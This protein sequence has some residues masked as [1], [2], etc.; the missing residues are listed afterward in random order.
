MK[1]I[2]ILFLIVMLGQGLNAQN[3]KSNVFIIGYNPVAAAAAKQSAESGVY[4]EWLLNIGGVGPN[5][6]ISGL[7]TLKNL[8]IISG[9][10]WQ[11]IQASGSSYHV[12]LSDGKTS[13]AK[14]LIIAGDPAVLAQL[15]IPLDSLKLKGIEINY[16]NP[17]YRTSIAAV[18]AENNNSNQQDSIYSFYDLLIPSFDNLIYLS[19]NFKPA[20]GQGAGAAAAYACFFGR[21]LSQGNLKA[22][23][24]ELFHYKANLFPLIDVNKNDP[25]WR[26][27]QAI[28]LM[29]VLKAEQT[30]EGWAIKPDSIVKTDE[31]RDIYKELYSKSHIWFEDLANKPFTLEKAID[32]IAYVGQKTPAQI[33]DTLQKNWEKV[34]QISTPFDLNSTITRREFAIIVQQFMP[35]FNVAVDKSG[36]IVK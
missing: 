22:I 32:L 33:S 36:N 29:G 23:Q 25:N 4:T 28:A 31:I 15:K 18:R 6:F 26:A 10:T 14:V 7:D 9:L 30:I 11:R 27:L 21:K 5:A 34:Y 19:A 16:Q 17:K 1:R 2:Y 20:V 35:P 24:G 13:K 8:K 3:P 12:K